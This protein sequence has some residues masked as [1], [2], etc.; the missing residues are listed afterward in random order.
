MDASGRQ[1]QQL[2]LSTRIYTHT[3]LIDSADVHRHCTWRAARSTTPLHTRRSISD[4]VLCRCAIWRTNVC[5]WR[6]SDFAAA[7]GAII[8]CRN[9]YRMTVYISC[10]LIV[11]ING[12]QQTS[13][14]FPSAREIAIHGTHVLLPTDVSAAEMSKCF[15]IP[16]NFVFVAFRPG[17]ANY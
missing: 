6:T 10:W 4:D 5:V 12:W 14:A 16:L 11:G 17:V 7:V 3:R 13:W 2:T 1:H 15:F 8:V 9:G